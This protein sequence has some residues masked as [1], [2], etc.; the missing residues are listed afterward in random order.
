[1]PQVPR[2]VKPSPQ[3]RRHYDS[4]VRRALAVETET[5]ILEAAKELFAERGYVG[6]SLAA[7]AD[8]AEI[9]ARTL[10]KIFA[11]KVELLSRLV[12]V[13]MVGDRFAIPVSE[14]DW[15]AGAFHG[16][17]GTERV[18]VFAAAIR[19]IMATA[20]SAF[21]TA[22]QAAAADEE[23]AVLWEKGQRHRYD[24]ATAFVTSLERSQL[25]RSDR[26][27]EHAI[28]TVWLV[29]SPET[30]MQLTDGRRITLDE[31][32]LWVEQTLSDAVLSQT[33]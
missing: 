14:R 20:G 23:A 5:R 8:R 28:A 1:M 7:I 21:R 32:E 13:S 16:E 17:S 31:Y 26:T 15:S 33:T 4:P 22:A 12:D 19:R 10:Y 29:T 6:T 27:R 11:R 2:A 18:R 25:L 9:N 3:N 24:D 30:F